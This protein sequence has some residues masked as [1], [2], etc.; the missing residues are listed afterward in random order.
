MGVN[1][2]VEGA[3]NLYMPCLVHQSKESVGNM[4]GAEPAVWV[5]PMATTNPSPARKR[6]AATMKPGIQ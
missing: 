3:L 5:R 1:E 6:G 2:I 4:V